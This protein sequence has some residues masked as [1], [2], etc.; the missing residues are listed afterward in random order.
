[1][2][3]TDGSDASVVNDGPTH[4]ATAYEIGENVGE[5]VGLTNESNRG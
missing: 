1:M 3:D 2:R 5:I 4:A